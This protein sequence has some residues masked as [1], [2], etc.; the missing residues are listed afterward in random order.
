MC[1]G[2]CM[3][4][5][6]L[7]ASIA[8]YCLAIAMGT[9]FEIQYFE[10]LAPDAKLLACCMYSVGEL[11]AVAA[12]VAL[13]HR[14]PSK[15]RGEVPLWLLV[16]GVVGLVSTMVGVRSG[17]FA[18]TALPAAGA[19][20]QGFQR[21]AFVV[22]WFGVAARMGDRDILLL[23][24]GSHLASACI[25]LMLAKMGIPWADIVG[26]C[27]AAMPFVSAALLR[28]ADASVQ[29][30]PADIAATS[31]WTFPMRPVAFVAVFTFVNNFTRS[32][33]PGQDAA[34][35]VL[36]VVAGSAPIIVA[37]FVLKERPVLPTLREVS[38]PVLV[39]GCLCLG[40]AGNGLA[41][42]ILTNAGFVCLDVF[43]YAALCRMAR[44]F[45]INPAWLI[46]PAKAA[47]FAASRLGELC[48]YAVASDPLVGPN[49]I[50]MVLV[51]AVPVLIL[52]FNLFA[53]KSDI[54]GT[55]GVVPNGTD[56]EDENESRRPMAP[57][58][59]AACV[60]REKGLTRREED[61][62]SQ[63]LLE[64]SALDIAQAL[65]VSEAT[66]RTHVQHIYKKLEVHSRTELQELCARVAAG[67]ATGS[68]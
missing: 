26:L 3:G 13:S 41:A 60:A 4:A 57:V 68:R 37:A 56:N 28:S 36:G 51:F 47:A 63:L 52:A 59:V 54:G 67:D 25:S 49:A 10:L 39:A 66:A 40:V 48:G 5:R 53:T 2:V 58:D 34:M 27:L 17:G 24:C 7:L 64:Q 8:G 33:L 50:G 20:L 12:I 62:L 46:G 42:G 45:Q 23:L 15:V 31:G 6:A 18:G 61:V 30:P 29:G 19:L 21:A 22:L 65:F 1:K 14:D 44:R 11:A 16:L 38:L 35:T 55:W 9:S 43:T 32:F